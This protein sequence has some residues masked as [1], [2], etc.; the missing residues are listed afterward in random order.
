LIP[1]E[2]G[3]DTAQVMPGA[4]IFIINGMGHD[5]PKGVWVKIVNAIS[6]HIMQAKV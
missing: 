3:K 5:M 4:R 6:Q 2:G 1:V